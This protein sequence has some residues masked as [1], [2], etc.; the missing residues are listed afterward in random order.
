MIALPARRDGGPVSVAAG[1]PVV[2]VKGRER[3][4][5]CDALL[6]ACFPPRRR[7]ELHPDANVSRN[8]SATRHHA[9]ILALPAHT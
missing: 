5:V 3:L 7:R 9:H 2:E 8:W 1:A 4:A 6:E